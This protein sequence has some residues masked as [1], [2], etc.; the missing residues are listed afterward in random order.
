MTVCFK[1]QKRAKNNFE[2]SCVLSYE[3]L[4]AEGKLKKEKGKYLKDKNP[5]LSL[6]F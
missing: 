3:D 2:R 4:L 5:Q 1:Y 6:D